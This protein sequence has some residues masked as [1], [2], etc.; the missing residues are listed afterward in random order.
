MKIAVIIIALWFGGS[1]PVVTSVRM[2]PPSMYW[3]YWHNMCVE[4]WN[5]IP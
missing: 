1:K 2:Y 4:A 3:G 5:E